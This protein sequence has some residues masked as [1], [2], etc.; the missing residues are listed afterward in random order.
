MDRYDEEISKMNLDLNNM[1]A[2]LKATIIEISNLNT[3]IKIL[4]A[5]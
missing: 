5:S 1:D 4:T 2:E 3:D